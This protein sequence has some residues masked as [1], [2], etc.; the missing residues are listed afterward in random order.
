MPGID[1]PL[2][3]AIATALA[4]DA[5]REQPA[6][7]PPEAR[8]LRRTRLRPKMK[9][10]ELLA[11]WVGLHKPKPKSVAAAEKA[12]R[13]FKSYVC[14]SAWKK[15]PGSGVIGVEKGPLISVI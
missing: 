6:V 4:S 5:V 11:E 12:V 15:D 3:D 13:D 9:L 10:D 2:A 1:E 14:G 7:A 8:R